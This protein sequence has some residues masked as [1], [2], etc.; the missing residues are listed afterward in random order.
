MKNIFAKLT[1]YPALILIIL[2]V[3]TF[4][5]LIRPGYFPMHDDLQAFR[6]H[7][8]NKCF[9]DFQIPC[10]WVPDMGY[11]YGYP[12]FNYY[13]PSVYYLGEAFHLVGFQF[14]DSAKIIFALG[15]IISALTMYLFLK[16]FLSKW[17]AFIGAL[18]YSYIPY[19][20]VSVYVRG[21][22]NEFWTLAFYPLLFW[23]S[24]KIIKKGGRKNI[25][26]FAISTALILLTHNLMTLIFLPV[27]G[28][29]ILLNIILEKNWKSL[30]PIISG[31]ILGIGLAAFFT[32]P[33]FFEQKYAH[34][35]TLVGGYFDYRQHFV[36]FYQLF[37]SNYWGY[38][39]SLFGIDDG[40]SLST[41]QIQVMG[42]ILAFIL[43]AINFKKFKKLSTITF[44]LV[45][46]ELGVLFMIH[47]RSS[48]IWTLFEDVLI[49][50]QFP[51]RFLSISVFLLSILCAI[52]V[53]FI[54]KLD[55]KILKLNAALIYGLVILLAC[56]AFYLP[57]FKPNKWY[58]I[59]DADKFSGQSWEK[60]LTIS[61]FDYLPI[62]AEF[63]PTA[64][65]PKNPQVLEGDAN[66][67][68][69]KIGS[70][71]KSWEVN[72]VQPSLLRSPVFDFPGMNVFIDGKK[73]DHWNNDCRNEEFCHGLITFNSEPGHHEILIKL[74]NTPVRSLGNIITLFSF[75]IL[76]ILLAP[77]HF[78]KSNYFKRWIE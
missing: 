8:M 78:L 3:P 55:L 77:L 7:Q 30:I 36:S 14:I 32:L 38:D 21:S 76:V 37:I 9:E 47:Q 58:D 46:L 27:L 18:V 59:T 22:L 73:V 28:T 40:M 70:N 17:P 63:P 44:A 74:S 42:A 56:I 61:I 64:P 66:F 69:S 24:L 23:S 50:V 49:F 54:Q 19:K 68:E 60:Q 33:V 67:G 4:F 48:P 71:F 45:V 51:W 34:L 75:M 1:K 41:G 10:R 2:I 6:I 26:F 52:G 35:E 29:W 53:F 12:Q 11:Q 72:V 57:F 5:S 13:P 43:A 25:A 31:G 20:A 65:A 62:Y 39:S 16:D 15:L